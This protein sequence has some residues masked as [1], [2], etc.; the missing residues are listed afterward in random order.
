MPAISTQLSALGNTG[1]TRL[2]NTNDDTT[3]NIAM[4]MT[5]KYGGADVTTIY[6]SGNSWVGFGSGT[7]HLNIN[8]RDASYN[9]LYYKLETMYGQTCFRL[10]FEGN[11]YYSSWGSNNLIWELICFPDG[12][13]T[14]IVVR[15]DGGGTSNF[16]SK[17][18]GTIS[19]G[20]QTGKSY[21]LTPADPSNRGTYYTISEG[22]YMPAITKYLVQ[23]GEEIKNY[24]E[25]TV[26]SKLASELN[27]RYIRD[28][29][30]G[31]TANT[32]N[33]WVE[34]QAITSL[35]ANIAQNKPVSS[36]G[37]IEDS[38][39]P[40]SRVT[41]NSTD[42]SLYV[43]ISMTQPAYVEI[44]LQQGYQLSTIKIWHY[45]SDSRTYYGT[46]TQVSEDGINWF[47]V[48]DSTSSGTYQESSSGKSLTLSSITAVLKTVQFSKI[49]DA[50]ATPQMFRDFGND[51]PHPTR[52]GIVKP[53]PTLLMWCDFAT[54]YDT[55]PPPN[56]YQT[57]VPHPK[58]V[59]MAND[60]FFNEAYIIGI[61]K[62]TLQVTCSGAS[63]LKFALSENGG[64]T[65]KAWYNNAW[66]SL[67]ISNMQDVKDRGMTKATL[68]AI[69]EAQWTSLGLSNKKIRFAW[70]M[71][72]VNLNSPVIVRQIKLDYKTQGV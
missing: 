36:N 52:V 59:K 16:D 67:D 57:G 55:N 31:S 64:V 7:Q 70:Y 46:K 39:R 56:I 44:D 47:T 26:F 69:T 20:C 3:V 34:I 41:D 27:I 49:G 35:G 29:V 33:H 5:M 22:Q 71:E 9:A 10:R 6:T 43:G 51:K 2:G 4:G 66:V 38:S 8:N 30:N 37:P 11:T 23:D 53:T 50:P 12:G 45:Y 32:G 58:L 25:T 24:T 72:Q 68:E 65:W 18:N 19:Y 21:A 1:M 60:E 13:M 54:M 14:L 28:W 63:V 15:N 62:A 61:V 48:F 17:G 40:L 42:T